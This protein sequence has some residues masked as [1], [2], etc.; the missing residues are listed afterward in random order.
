MEYSVWPEVSLRGHEGHE[1]LLKSRDRA[2]SNGLVNVRER[3][4]DIHTNLRSRSSNMRWHLSSPREGRGRMY[5]MP[6]S[7]DMGDVSKKSV[8]SA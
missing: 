5:C 7:S 2:T 4:M 1:A 6:A 3:W 8:S